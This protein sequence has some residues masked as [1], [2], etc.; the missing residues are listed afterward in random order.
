MIDGII[1]ADGTSRLMRAELPATY[2]EFREQCK[3]GTQLLDILFNS[4]GWSQLP[5]FLNKANLLRDDTASLFGLT[6]TAVPND[7]FNVLSRLNNVLCSEYVWAKSEQYT[8]DAIIRSS[9]LTEIVITS[10]DSGMTVYTSATVSN[11]AIVLSGSTKVNY[12]Q[13]KN[14]YIK[15][16][17]KVYLLQNNTG[18]GSSNAYYEAYELTVG[19]QTATRIVG[20][21]NSPNPNAY[22]INDGFIYESLGQLGKRVTFELGS[23]AGTGKVGPSNPNTLTFDKPPVMVLLLGAR[24]GAN[25]QHFFGSSNEYYRHVMSPPVM[26]T[27][28]KQTDGFGW[29][30][31]GSIWGKKSED[32]KTLT[33]YRGDS[34]GNALS[35]ANAADQRNASGYTY[36][37]LA[38]FD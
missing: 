36:Y 16:S 33:W 23:Y 34:N 5:T 9:S 32:G 12:N 24:F 21:V 27:L 1:K 38:F 3:S 8:A 19:Q 18:Y 17:N 31:N 14:Y 6:E 10:V 22:P 29:N 7:L 35:N 20:Y 11:G 15:K 28:Y 26:S 4:E 30:S 25:T 2:E 37:Y 13:G